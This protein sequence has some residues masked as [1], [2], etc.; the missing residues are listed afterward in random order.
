MLLRIEGAAIDLLA[1]VGLTDWTVE[2]V[3]KR[4]GCAK[5]L[6]HYHYNSKSEL[7]ARVAER[8]GRRRHER[9]LK[10]LAPGG[11]PSIDRLWIDLTTEVNDGEAAAWLALLSLPDPRVRESMLARMNEVEELGRAAI[12]AFGID[13][14]A[15]EVGHLL[16][17]VTNGTQIALVRGDDPVLA[18][19]AYH[20]FWL[21]L[22][23]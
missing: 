8:M 11:P 13:G 6:V 9:R 1:S 15:A 16:E 4:A 22:L 14:V 3:A 2:R 23:P 17:I 10:A 21:G 20:R 18:Q 7:L 5:G 12:G 19:E